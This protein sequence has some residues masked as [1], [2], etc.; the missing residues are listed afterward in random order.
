MSALLNVIVEIT[1]AFEEEDR[2][3][4]SRPSATSSAFQSTPI[5]GAM[6]VETVCPHTVA[7]G[8]G[9]PGVGYVIVMGIGERRLTGMCGVSR[10][11]IGGQCNGARR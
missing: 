6:F 9:R 10:G 11:C 4:D 8:E 5:S 7:R 1:K 2:V 3:R